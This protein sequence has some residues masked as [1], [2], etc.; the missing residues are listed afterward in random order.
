MSRHAVIV[1]GGIAGATAAKALAARGVR[2][3]LLE[4]SGMLCSGSTWHAAGL[5]TRFAGSPKLKKIH[6]RSIAMLGELEDRFGIGLHRPGSIRIIEKGNTDRLVEAKQ[7]VAMAA[8]YDDPEFPTELLSA[9]EVAAL[10]PLLDSSLVECGVFTPFDGDVDPTS[11][12]NCVARLAKD[13]GAEIRFNAD[14]TGVSRQPDGRFSVKLAPGP[15][16]APDTVLDPI[17][18]DIVINAAGLWSRN[19]SDMAPVDPGQAA[20]SH[21]AFVIEHQYAITETVPEVKRLA[22]SGHN[23]GRLPVLRDLKGSSYIRQEGNG[24]LIGPYEE[25]CI[26]R[27]DMPR[28]PPSDFVMELFPDSLDRIEDNLLQ[29]IELVPCL[30]EVGFKTVV[31]GPTIWTGDSLARVGRTTI[32]GWYDF[33]SLTYGIAQSLALSEYLAHIVLE[34]EQPS[35]LDAT[36]YFDPLRYGAWAN[37]AFTVAKIQETY[38]HNNRIVYPFENRSGGLGHVAAPYPLHAV[39]A[40]HGARFGA[41]GGAGCEAPL[42]FSA[43]SAA[44]STASVS[45]SAA[46]ATDEAAAPDFHDEKRFSHF[47]WAP[48]AEEE[49]AHALQHVGLAYSSFSKIRVRGKDSA[50]FLGRAT[51]APLPALRKKE[52]CGPEDRPC[53]LTYSTTPLGRVQTEFTL[54]RTDADGQEWYLVGSR[55]HVRQD[56]AWLRQ[57]VHSGEDVAVEDITDEVCV[58]HVC[59]PDSGR[60]LTA[61][62]PRLSS[63]GFMRARPVRDF[64]GEQGLDIQAFRVSFTGELGF[65]LHVPA[66]DGPRLHAALWNHQ[67]AR[68]L[69]LRHIGSAA[70]NSLRIEKAFKLRPDLD[71]AHYS[72]A[73]IGPFLSKKRDFLGRD[74]AFEP[75]RESAVFEV[76]TPAGWE[77]SVQGDSPVRRASDDAIVGFTTTSARGA[78]TKKTIALGFV[79]TDAGLT[80]DEPLYLQTF[81]EHWPVRLLPAPPG[82]VNRDVIA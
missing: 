57:C 20:L 7:H 67:S 18:C 14:V 25:E 26:V 23:G 61:V 75:T 6:V 52:D 76:A 39:L 74:D 46:L 44:G 79:Q 81:G 54:C 32:P 9:S 78:I 50:A 27:T 10:H 51:T 47:A 30:G 62:E 42:C 35:W 1:G 13:D 38:T 15:G 41:I 63:L 53:R 36:D 48:I 77:W 33:N 31:N 4:R 58:L 43:P 5:V 28:G 17:E 55:D 40:S 65:E 80:T 2:V 16:L 59:G 34:G 37:D 24:F 56:V 66:A 22:E 60:L 72:E 49:A 69:E 19:V 68:E 70:I 73:G 71:F 11:L 21:P 45:G 64:A 3:T 82:E 8:L 12:T 29:G